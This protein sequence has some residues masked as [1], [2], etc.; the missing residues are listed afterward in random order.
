[1]CDGDWEHENG[2]DI[3]TCDNPCWSVKIGVLYTTL[4]S[5]S[6]KTG[7]VETS[8]DD[9]YNITLKDGLYDAGGDLSKLDF[10]IARF[11]Q[12]VEDHN[13]TYRLE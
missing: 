5:V 9:W 11:R 2:I 1:M 12:L 3:K 6:F 4:E 7:L 10:L 13:A 8:E